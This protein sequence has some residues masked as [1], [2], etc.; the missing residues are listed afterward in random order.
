MQEDQR[1]FK[2]FKSENLDDFYRKAFPGLVHFAAHLLGD[3]NELLA[4]DCAQEAVIKAWERKEHFDTVYAFKSFLYTSIRNSIIDIHR[5]KTV[6]ERFV[7]QWEE[8]AHFRNAVI[9]QEIQTSLYNAIHDLPSKVREV[10]EMLF[11]E[12]LKISEIA[13]RLQLSDRMI[14]NYRADALRLLREKL[15]PESFNVILLFIR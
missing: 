5:K 13:E 15:D 3:S 9:D 7:K 14:R 11:F 10:F 6:H 4:E 8:P 12:G 2:A 1:I